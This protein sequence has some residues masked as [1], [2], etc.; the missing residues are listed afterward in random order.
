MVAVPLTAVAALGGLTFMLA[1]LLILASRILYVQEDPRL[2]IV[3]KIY[4]KAR[5]VIWL[6]PESR[7]NWGSGDSEMLRYQSACHQ[8]FEC[9]SLQQLERFIDQLLRQSR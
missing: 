5:Q 7:A 1:T 3:K 4:L 6:N 9:Q 8:V 2:D